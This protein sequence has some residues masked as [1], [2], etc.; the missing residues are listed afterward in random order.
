MAPQRDARPPQI[1][2]VTDS[3]GREPPEH[4]Q[5]SPTRAQQLIHL[6]ALCTL[7]QDAL[8]QLEDGLASEE[9]M[10]ALDETCELAL[11][12]THLRDG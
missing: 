2:A 8:E 9:L 7:L 11:L 1:G 10:A 4:M 12:P 3:G 5:E 6:L